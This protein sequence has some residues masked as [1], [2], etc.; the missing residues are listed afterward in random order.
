MFKSYFKIFAWWTLFIFIGT[1]IANLNMQEG[2]ETILSE[3]LGS[4]MAGGILAAALGTINARRCRKVAAGKVEG[5]IYSADQTRTVK[6]ALQQDR[7][8]HLVSHYLREVAKYTVLGSD[9]VSAVIE[10][11]TP[12]VMFKGLGSRITAQVAK[13]GEGS[14]VTIRCRPAVPPAIADYGENLALALSIE[15]YLKEA[16][17]R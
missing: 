3:L 7:A 1:L 9:Q 17:R 8:F 4:V 13:D 2:R 14:L 6:M 10:A 5:D 16:D 12:A 11:K 15:N